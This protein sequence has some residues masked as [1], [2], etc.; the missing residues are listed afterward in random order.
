LTAGPSPLLE[1]FFYDLNRG[2][3]FAIRAEEVGKR[4]AGRSES[5]AKWEQWAK[6]VGVGWR[7]A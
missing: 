3:R 1:Q 6:T 2:E 4:L 5:A 7:K